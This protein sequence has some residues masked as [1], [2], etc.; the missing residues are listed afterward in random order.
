MTPKIRLS[1]KVVRAMKNS[2]Y[3][4]KIFEFFINLATITIIAED[5]TSMEE[6]SR[7]FN[8]SWNH[9]NPEPQRKLQRL[10]EKSSIISKKTG[11]EEDA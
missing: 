4:E 2:L 8:E 10:Y 9:P 6:E 11:M 3:H 7:S 5:A 1:P